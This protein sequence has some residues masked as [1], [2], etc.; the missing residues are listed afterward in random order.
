[1]RMLAEKVGCSHGNLYLHFKNKEE[2]FDC[3][4]EE[5]F[6]QL[7]DTLHEAYLAFSGKDNL[8]FLRAAGRA[9]VNFGLRNPSAYEFAF[10]LRRPGVRAKAHRA[11]E[12][13][14]MIVALCV[15]EKSIPDIDVDTAAQAAWAAV[16]GVT[17]L[18]ILQPSFPWADEQ[19]VVDRVIDS[20]VSGL[21]RK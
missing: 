9:Y 4:V 13:L 19:A 11:Y 14:R 1:M 15:E 2:I 5:S 3:L 7:A 18:L 16:H 20:A 12:Y 10:I 6:E 17:S 21:A 8:E